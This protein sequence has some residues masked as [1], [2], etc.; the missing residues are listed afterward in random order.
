MGHGEI[1]DGMIKDGLWCAIEDV[2][3]GITAENLAERYNISRGEWTSA[4]ESQRRAQE[5]IAKSA[6][7]R[8]LCRWKFPS[9]RRPCYFRYR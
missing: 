1:E 7:P 8:K 2:H 3:M 5:A 9:A 6:S 4:A